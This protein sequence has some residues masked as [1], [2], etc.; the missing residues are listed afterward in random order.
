MPQ[1]YFLPDKKDVHTDKETSILEASLNAGIPHTNVCG[2]NARCSTCR[3][4]ILDGME[5]CSPRTE[6]EQV[7]A[8]R[9][10]FDSSIRL[11]CQTKVSGKVNLRRLVLDDED[12]KLTSQLK[13]DLAPVS[14]GEEKD[15]AILFADIRGFT[16]F[17][18]A[19]V[20]YDV[21][22]VLNRYFH[23]ME[24]VINQNGGYIDNY[25]G[26]GLLALFGVEKEDE[27]P[28]KAVKAGLEM[29]EEMEN[30]RPY[31]QSIYDKCWEI[32]IGIHYGEAVI[33]TIGGAARRKTI[34]GDSVNFASRIESANK[35]LDTK[36][37]ISQQVYEHV[38][39]HVLANQRVKLTIK[40]KTG[41]YT[42]YE[43][44]GLD[45]S[46]S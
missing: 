8:E 9:L 26:D 28:L 16:T 20:P 25:M 34:I 41:K 11:A 5:C 2:G 24:Q 39:Q 21:I 38:K 40:G 46:S 10:N 14:V 30:L 45:H 36:L 17:A 3:V 37:L 4:M 12:V 23:R 18:E 33:G 43:I 13:K 35:E 27:A 44:I 7:L 32:G 19:L 29:L 22:H 31:L 42:L 15:V 6:K 1:I